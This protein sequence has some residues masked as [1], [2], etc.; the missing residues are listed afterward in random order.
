[1]SFAVTERT[2]MD[3]EMARQLLLRLEFEDEARRQLEIKKKIEEEAER[4]AQVAIEGNF[5]ELSQ[6]QIAVQNEL[7]R[8]D[9]K[10]D[11]HRK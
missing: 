5:Y 3:A 2:A 10:W 8:L 9:I 7:N 1:M 4:S 11:A 6:E